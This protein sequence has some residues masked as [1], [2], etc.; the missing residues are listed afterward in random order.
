M[1]ML[2]NWKVLLAVVLV[3]IAGTVTGWALSVVH[4][5]H[6]F[7]RGFTVE[8]WISTTMGIL[9]KDLKLTPDQEP[10]VRTI[11]KETGEK[12]RE[13]F[14]QAIRVSGTNLVASWDRI[15]RVLTPDQQLIHRRKC[16][17]FREKVSKGLKL[18]LP[19]NSG[20]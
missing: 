20:Q 10:K 15:D 8:N 1:K 17:E 16:Q 19:P 4:F 12:F 6:A 3:F 14:G 11:V 7:E 5:K 18:D 9:Q 2:K 13:T